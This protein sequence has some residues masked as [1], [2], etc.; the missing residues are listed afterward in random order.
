MNQT[1][2]FG[3]TALSRK[4]MPFG[5]RYEFSAEGVAA[6]VGGLRSEDLLDRQAPWM[7]WRHGA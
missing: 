6:I 2:K 1:K 7:G 5:L 3:S 4:M